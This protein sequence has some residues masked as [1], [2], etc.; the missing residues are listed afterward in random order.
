ML[1]D[2]HSLVFHLEMSVQV[3]T[4]DSAT[5]A[6]PA[7]LYIRTKEWIREQERLPVLTLWGPIALEQIDEFYTSYRQA[8]ESRI[9][10]IKLAG[11]VNA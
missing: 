9:R 1:P 11:I 4:I 5:A 3:I 8:F 10:S 2:L 7:G 6:M